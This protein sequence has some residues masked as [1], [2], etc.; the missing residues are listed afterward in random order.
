VLM[1]DDD[2]VVRRKIRVSRGREAA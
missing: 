1:D 2:D